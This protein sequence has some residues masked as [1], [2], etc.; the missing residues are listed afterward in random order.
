MIYRG[1]YSVYKGGNLT[2]E[3]RHLIKKTGK[4]MDIVIE[5][6]GGGGV[7]QFFFSDIF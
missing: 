4:K 3:R 2:S 6:G 7:D 1:S 5:G